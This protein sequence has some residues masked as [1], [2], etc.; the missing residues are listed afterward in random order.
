MQTHALCRWRNDRVGDATKLH[1]D[2]RCP[3]HL[4]EVLGQNAFNMIYNSH[5]W[6]A[7]LTGRVSAHSSHINSEIQCIL[8]GIITEDASVKNNVHLLSN[9]NIFRYMF[10]KCKDDN[11]SASVLLM[12]QFTQQWK[13]V[14]NY[15][16]SFIFE[17]QHKTLLMK[18]RNN[19]LI[20]HRQQCS[21]LIQGPETTDVTWTI[22][23][24]SLLPLWA[25]NVSVALLSKQGQK[26]LGF[27]QKNTLICVTKMSKCRLERHEGE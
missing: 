16:P 9:S 13:A 5:I 18:S 10:I 3:V 21:W 12:G 8:L 20:P 19:F 11:A 4:Q 1:S 26:A 6:G 2:E 27:Q 7:Y 14:I 23:M 15:S 25:L 22:L 24:M 17:T